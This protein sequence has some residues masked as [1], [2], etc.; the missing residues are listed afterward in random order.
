MGRPDCQAPGAVFGRTPTRSAWPELRRDWIGSAPLSGPHS[1]FPRAPPS[2]PPS[3][4]RTPPPRL[5]SAPVPA[6]PQLGLVL[7]L[8]DLA[9]YIVTLGPLYTI[10]KLL[11]ARSTFAAPVGDADINQVGGCMRWVHVGWQ[12]HHCPRLHHPPSTAHRQLP[13]CFSPTSPGRDPRLHPNLPPAP[14]LKMSPPHHHPT[15]T[16]PPPPHHP[17][18]APPHH[19][20]AASP[21][22]HH[23]TPP[24][25]LH[26]RRASR[27]R[28][29][30]NPSRPLR[31]AS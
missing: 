18:T 29:S 12:A 15:T 1:R 3:R 5:I 6:P 16:P 21:P 10:Y 30:G 14:C 26:P 7:V 9:I 31:R 17:T 28:R 4:P 22:H 2:P 19:Q 23:S 20:P 24:P 27:R 13:L 25:P 11:T 8:L